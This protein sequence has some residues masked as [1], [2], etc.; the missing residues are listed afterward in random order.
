MRQIE[1]WIARR[2]RWCHQHQTRDNCHECEQHAKKIDV[3]WWRRFL[4]GEFIMNLEQDLKDIKQQIEDDEVE[5]AEIELFYTGLIMR[6]SREGKEKLGVKTLPDSFGHKGFVTWI[7][8]LSKDELQ[9]AKA[10]FFD[11]WTFETNNPIDRTLFS[12]FDSW[13]T[14]R[15]N[16][17][18]LQSK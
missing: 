9:R 15:L 2:L 11:L 6:L 8:G 14:L 3:K 7:A 13:E 12:I 1:S 16:P 17:I 10:H 18:C 5:L 4:F